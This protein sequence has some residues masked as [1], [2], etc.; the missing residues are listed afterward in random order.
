MLVLLLNIASY[1]LAF[2]AVWLGAGLIVES[3]SRF[4][5]RLRLSSFAFSFI[6]L[7]LLTSTPEFS[8]GL[9]AIADNNPE[10]FTGNLL[11]G[12]VIIFLLVIPLLAVVGNGVNLRH[13]L[14]HH[15]LIVALLVIAAPSFLI[16][17]KK[18]TNAEGLILVI[19]YLLLLLLVE[20]KHGIL[21]NGNA[22]LFSVKSYSYTDILK[23]FFGIAALFISSSIIV[24]K[25]IY[26]AD[27]FNI[28]AFYFGLII[29][30]LGTNMPEISIAIRSAIEK[31]KDIAMGDYLGS[32]S[33]NTLLFGVFTLLNN[34]EVLTV[35]N[36][37]V[38]FIFIVG[39]LSIFYFFSYRQ[40]YISRRNGLVLLSGY[41]VFVIVELAK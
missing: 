17:D 27:F 16:L 26:F 31:K 18:V 25:T 34:G 4:S 12:I 32:A 33:A 40:K 9:Q 20:R 39:A 14:S 41:I 8:V 35:D 5:N 21:D 3:T 7:G 2:V 15:N 1:A 13:E 28:S 23:I 10:I 19:A 11:G 37:L 6:F 29:V 38:T 36:F 24:D 22:K 30:S